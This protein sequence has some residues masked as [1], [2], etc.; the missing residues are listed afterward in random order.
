[1]PSKSKKRALPNDR[2]VRDILK[3]K[4]SQGAKLQRMTVLAQRLENDL[5][6]ILT[7][8]NYEGG[9]Q[10]WIAKHDAVVLKALCISQ[11]LL[12]CNACASVLFKA[13]SRPKLRPHARALFREFRTAQTR[14]RR[15]R[16]AK[17]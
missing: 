14:S 3:A 6:T 11:A 1:M 12:L 10:Y 7:D 17:P 8:R 15:Q 4:I 5:S 2:W 16:S 9:V 13:L